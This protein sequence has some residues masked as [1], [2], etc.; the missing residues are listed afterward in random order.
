MILGIPLYFFWLCGS[1]QYIWHCHMAEVSSHN[2][3]FCPKW[4][5]KCFW[6]PCFLTRKGIKPSL[7]FYQIITLV[8][9]TVFYCEWE[10]ELNVEERTRMEY[11]TMTCYDSG[12]IILFSTSISYIALKLFG[13]HPYELDGMFFLKKKN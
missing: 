10:N 7:L 9:S 8:K 4:H 12:T 3:K 13:L 1:K 5:E 2:W 11:Q 6:G